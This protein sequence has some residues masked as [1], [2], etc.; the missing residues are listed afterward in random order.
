MGVY[1]DTVLAD[2]PSAYWQ[3]GEASGNPQDSSGNARHVTGIVGTPTY[4]QTGPVAGTTAIA[5]NGTTDYFTVP[6]TGL[7]V[8]DV[9]TLEAWIIRGATGASRGIL[10]GGASEGYLRVL[11]TN[12]LTINSA[13]AGIISTSTVLIP[14]TGW[15]HVVG[16]KNAGSVHLYLDGADVSGTVSNLT[17]VSTVQTFFIGLRSLTGEFF[18]GTIGQAAVYPTVLTA[19]QVAAHYAAASAVQNP[20]TTGRHWAG[21]NLRP[22]PVNPLA[23]EADDEEVLLLVSAA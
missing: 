10:S 19:G 16:T 20:V 17:C 14:G 12:A 4:G 9:F 1:S 3:L 22:Q 23:I 6:G 18:N 2:H 5:F 15:H 21:R 8:G 11:N 13:S 7:N